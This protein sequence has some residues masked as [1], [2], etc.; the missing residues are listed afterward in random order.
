MASFHPSRLSLA[1]RRRGFTQVALAEAL[2]VTRL[3]IYRYEIGEVD[4]PPEALAKLARVLNFPISFFD[5]ADIDEP[6]QDSASFR[7]LTAMTARQRDCALAAGALA[8]LLDDWVRP[9]VVI[10]PQID[11][12][13]L[14]GEDPDIAARALRQ[15]W[16]L[17]ER[18]VRNAVHLLESKGIRVFS[19]AEETRTVDAFSVWRNEKPYVFLNTMKT[20]ERS[21]MDAL[22]ELAH[23]LLHKHGGPRG[24]AAEEEA[25]QFARAFLMPEA[26]VKAILPMVSN[27][28]QIL[29]RKHRWGVSAF[30]LVYRLHRLGCISDWAYQR[31]AIKL[32]ELGY[33]TGEPGGRSPEKS[34]FW[35]KVFDELRAKKMTK[36]T[37]ADA[38]SLPVAEIENLVFRL[39]NMTTFEGGALTA[40]KSRARLRV[41]GS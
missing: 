20:T 28:Q 10:A 41:I 33:R 21:R 24:K 17:G 30:N 5:G 3:T 35:Q 40:G 2:G 32:T 12:P 6:N 8:F 4:P 29:Y 39:A 27:V 34:L 7:G 9:L 15:K 22:H 37:I 18:P 23:L 25:N 36:H 26:D 38:L 14:E 11:L 19:L 16:G 1:R 31:L 13:D